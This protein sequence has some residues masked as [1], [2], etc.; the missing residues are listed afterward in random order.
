MNEEWLVEEEQSNNSSTTVEE[1]QWLEE[2]DAT[3]YT[4]YAE[5]HKDKH[6]NNEI[7]IY[8]WPVVLIVLIAAVYA[9]YYKKV[10]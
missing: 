8:D 5:G 1:T 7:P 3:T 9:H 4:T 10:R 6:K 2:Q